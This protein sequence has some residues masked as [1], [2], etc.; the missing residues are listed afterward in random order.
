MPD[1]EVATQHTR[2]KNYMF[3]PVGMHTWHISLALLVMKSFKK[4]NLTFF[5]CHPIYFFKN[6]G[7]F[8]PSLLQFY[9]FLSIS[10]ES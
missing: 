3:I 4:H 10:L 5:K 6:L 9:H 1:T 8:H 7:L 2:L